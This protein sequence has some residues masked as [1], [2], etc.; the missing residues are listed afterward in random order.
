[1][2]YCA[3]SQGNS[4]SVDATGMP[5]Y[6]VLTLP[7]EELALTEATSRLVDVHYYVEQTAMDSERTLP[8]WITCTDPS[9]IEAALETDPSVGGYE[10]VRDRG[11]EQLYEVTVAERLLIVREVVHEHQGT[12]RE[13]HGDADGWVFEVRFPD[14]AAL[15]AADELFERYGVTVNY[16][17][18]GATDGTNQRQLHE[19]TDA[20]RELLEVAL[21]EGYYDIPRR[22][23]L[24]DLADQAGVT[25]STASRRLRNLEQRLLP[26]LTRYL[27]TFLMS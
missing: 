8:L 22:I 25:K 26:I 7:T 4:R 12:I 27:Q 16:E 13:V 9:N 17:R 11:D 15:S 2:Y 14:R 5:T 21:D 10:F 24:A 3:H 6:A 18:I 19:L 20:Q 23:S 1:M